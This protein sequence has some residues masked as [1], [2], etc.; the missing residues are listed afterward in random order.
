MLRDRLIV[1]FLSV[2]LLVIGLLFYGPVH[3]FR[4]EAIL[5]GSMKPALD[6]GSLVLIRELKP[7]QYQAGDIVSFRPP[8]K[9]G[10]NVTHRIVSLA[11]LDGVPAMRTKGD[12][13]DSVD[14]WQSSL[15]AVTGKTLFSVPWL[16]YPVAWLKQPVG[17]IAVLLVTFCLCVLPELMELWRSLRPRSVQPV[18]EE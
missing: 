7:W 15:G 17:F 8:T 4:V 3:G 18:A 12:A 6:T 1:G 9:D 14:P 11:M 13:N 5:S 2:S 16:G 10:G